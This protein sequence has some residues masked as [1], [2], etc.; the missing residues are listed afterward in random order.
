MPA[1][2]PR[3]LLMGLAQ[4]QKSMT[5]GM[6]AALPGVK[7]SAPPQMAPSRPT[8]KHPYPENF[9]KRFGEAPT[10]SQVWPQDLLNT[11]LGLPPSNTMRAQDSRT[12]LLGLLNG[13]AR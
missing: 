9:D 2:D 5:P 6:M 8:Q 10:S 12:Q 1:F 11:I 3:D 4:G 13:L 7:T